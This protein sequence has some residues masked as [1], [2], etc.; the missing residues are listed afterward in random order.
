MEISQL[1]FE[2]TKEFSPEMSKAL[3]TLQGGS[4]KYIILVKISNRAAG[5]TKLYQILIRL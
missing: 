2:S 4:P 5:C 3:A 1:T